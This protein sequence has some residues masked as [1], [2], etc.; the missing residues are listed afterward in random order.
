MANARVKTRLTKEDARQLR[1]QLTQQAE[2]A[3]DRPA[4]PSIVT[5]THVATRGHFAHGNPNHVK[6]EAGQVNAQTKKPKV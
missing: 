2:A 6:R 1:A 3:L 5:P 4:S